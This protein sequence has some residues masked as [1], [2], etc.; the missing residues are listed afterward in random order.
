M[1]NTVFILAVLAAVIVIAPP[2][3][4]NPA[5]A[6]VV[7]LPLGPATSA[8]IGCNTMSG[9]PHSGCEALRAAY[10]GTIGRAGNVTIN[11]GFDLRASRFTLNRLWLGV[12]GQLESGANTAQAAAV[13][14]S[15]PGIR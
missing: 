3:L 2:W 10:N 12:K 14:Q 6:T 9:L 8:E 4:Y 13:A 7:R 11:L 15:A 1:K 5:T